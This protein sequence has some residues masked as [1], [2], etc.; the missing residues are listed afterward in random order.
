MFG[1]NKREV[2]LVEVD[3]NNRLEGKA[4]L[5]FA[6]VTAVIF[7]LECITADSYKP[8][9]VIIKA[10]L[11]LFIGGVGIWLRY[12][13][14]K[15]RKITV[16][17]GGRDNSLY[18]RSKAL[19]FLFEIAVYVISYVAIISL[20]NFLSNGFK[21]TTDCFTEDHGRYSFIILLFSYNIVSNYL[22]L[23]SYYQAPDKARRV[24]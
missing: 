10:A 6:A 4:Y 23:Y 18:V 19:Y 8:A 21:F 22:G 17:I 3:C 14:H 24:L 20:I 2:F 11:T 12:F 9:S 16:T 13:R 5:I 7:A 1:R 15:P